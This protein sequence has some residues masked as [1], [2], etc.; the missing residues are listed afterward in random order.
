M[1]NSKR[2]GKMK[3]SPKAKT[4]A[5]GYKDKRSRP[6]LYYGTDGLKKIKLPDGTI[7]W[8]ESNV[9]PTKT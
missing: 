7:R 4:I 5:S 1:A 9:H 3:A 2:G 6:G 8:V